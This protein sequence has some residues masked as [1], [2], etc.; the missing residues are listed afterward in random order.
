MT[1]SALAILIFDSFFREID[2]L[3]F[4]SFSDDDD[5]EYY[6][7]D[8]DVS[9]RTDIEIMKWNFLVVGEIFFNLFVEI[10]RYYI[11]SVFP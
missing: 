8:G 9:A 6:D 5:D 11:L 4:T 1:L 7:V 10:G 3:D 2:L